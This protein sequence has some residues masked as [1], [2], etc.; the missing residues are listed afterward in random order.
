M[1]EYEQD[2]TNI[3]LWLIIKKNSNDNDDKVHKNWHIKKKNIDAMIKL[4]Q[5]NVSPLKWK[6]EFTVQIALITWGK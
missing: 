4:M 1:K 2:K 6:E 3:S 5:S